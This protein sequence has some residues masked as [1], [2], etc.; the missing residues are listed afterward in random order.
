MRRGR[1]TSRLGVDVL[2]KSYAKCV[3]GRDEVAKR[4]IAAAL[5][6]EDNTR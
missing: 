3:E 2:L 5:A 4:R 1:V 6:K